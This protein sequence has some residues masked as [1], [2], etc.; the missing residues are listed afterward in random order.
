MLGGIDVAAEIQS[1]QLFM[2][3][4]NTLDV[5]NAK[6]MPAAIPPATKRVRCVFPDIAMA[7]NKS[8]T[9]SPT[10]GLN[11][12]PIAS[13]APAATWAEALSSRCSK[14]IAIARRPNWTLFTF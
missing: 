9:T 3:P 14:A 8:T 13:V 12:A 10:L 2:L 7:A 11:M 4:K 1:S 6:D 5:A